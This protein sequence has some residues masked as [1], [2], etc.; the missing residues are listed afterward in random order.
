MISYGCS[1]VV[2]MT[3]KLARAFAT[4]RLCRTLRRFKFSKHNCPSCQAMTRTVLSAL[5]C[6]ALAISAQA[7]DS[8][9]SCYDSVTSAGSCYDSTT[10]VVTC[11]VA[12]ADCP[13]YDYPAGYMSGYSG[14]CHCG[15]S[16]NHTLETGTD[17]MSSYY[18]GCPPTP[19]PTSEGC[20]A[21]ETSVGSCYDSTTHAVTCNVASADCSGYAYAAG[22]MS[23]YSGCC[24][25]GA[26]CNHT[27]ETGSDC[28]SSYYDGC[29][30][31]HVRPGDA[32]TNTTGGV[33]ASGADAASPSPWAQ[34]RNKSWEA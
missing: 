26:S 17:C 11:D 14:C 13:G 30:T 23:G 27:A 25:C 19:A 8:D 34:M 18:E 2:V 7:N 20:F 10:H 33:G 12:E 3:N 6:V 32:T 24:H 5:C 4:G 28:M 22:Y 29:P 15:A 31:Q 1:S 9:Y 21:Q 16:C